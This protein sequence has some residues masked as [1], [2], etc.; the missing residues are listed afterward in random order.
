M[1]DYI[2]MYMYKLLHD[3]PTFVSEITHNK[4]TVAI[5]ITQA[6]VSNYTHNSLQILVVPNFTKRSVL[7]VVKKKKVKAQTI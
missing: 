1:L 6:S 3:D 7:S 4:L 5:L 2:Y